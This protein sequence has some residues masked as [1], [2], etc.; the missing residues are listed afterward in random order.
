MNAL[1]SLCA[2]SFELIKEAPYAV[3]NKDKIVFLMFLG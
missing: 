1:F 2:E 3:D